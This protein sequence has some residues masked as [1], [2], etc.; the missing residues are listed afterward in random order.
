MR[1]EKRLHNG[2]QISFLNVSDHDNDLYRIII[3]CAQCAHCKFSI[4]VDETKC[5]YKSDSKVS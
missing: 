5:S 1:Q 4:T 2:V 3:K